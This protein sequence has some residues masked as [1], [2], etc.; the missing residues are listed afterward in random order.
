[1]NYE[2][3]KPATPLGGLRLHMNE[4]T[5]GCSPAVIDALRG[6]SGEQVALYPDYTAA[7]EAAARRLRVGPENLV[8]T[9]GLDEGIFA[10]SV[11]V[12]RG[13]AEQD[14]LEAIVVPP[15]FEMYAVCA[16]AAGARVI[17]VPQNERFEFPLDRVLQA[18]NART[19]IV[20]LTNPNNPTGIVI[21]RESILAIAKAAPAAVI[22]VDEAYADFS[23]S[24]LI[25]DESLV[26]LTNVLIGRTFS[27]CYGLAGLRVGALVGSSAR[28]AAVRRVLPPY[29][30]NAAAAAAL[31]AALGDTAHYDSYLA[32]AQASKDML[33]AALDR[34]GIPYWRSAANFVLARLAKTP[35]GSSMV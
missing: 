33:Y 27:K 19:R 4:N 3:E 14:P 31:P 21:P 29:S 13:S 24:S 25:G 18:V 5:S 11:A 23:G 26:D 20:F 28:I 8:L 17:S 9:N 34:L 1:M 35:D 16:H 15:A 22:F 6:I 12:L 7:N 2:Y 30:V 32:Q 10:T